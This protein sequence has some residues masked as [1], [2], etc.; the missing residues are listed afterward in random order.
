MTNTATL[1]KS[2]QN[3]A[4]CGKRKYIL[5]TKQKSYSFLK[6]RNIQTEQ[7]KRCKFEFSGDRERD[8]EKETDRWTDRQTGR[9]AETENYKIIL[10][11]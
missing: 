9:Q 4:N 10:N 1:N 5:R 3:T 2:N 11:E 8:R 7:D 6:L